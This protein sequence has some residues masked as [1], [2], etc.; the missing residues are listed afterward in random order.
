MA[1]GA[2]L[3]SHQRVVEVGG[4]ESQRCM[5]ITAGVKRGWRVV[6]CLSV[7]LGVSLALENACADCQHAIVT[8]DAGCCCND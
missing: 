3:A 7:G 2:Q 4:R 6:G 5:A 8:R 1:G